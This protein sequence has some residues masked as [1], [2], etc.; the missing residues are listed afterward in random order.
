[1][2]PKRETRYPSP[3]DGGAGVGLARAVEALQGVEVIG[4]ELPALDHLLRHIA[5]D[6]LE[7]GDGAEQLVRVDDLISGP[8]GAAEQEDG[9]EV[10][11]VDVDRPAGDGQP[12]AP[13]FEDEAPDQRLLQPRQ[14]REQRLEQRYLALAQGFYQQLGGDGAAGV[15]LVGELVQPVLRQVGAVQQRRAVDLHLLGRLD[16]RRQHFLGDPRALIVEQGLDHGHLAAFDQRLRDGLGNHA[17]ARDRG[18]VLDGAAAN[19]IDQLGVVEQAAADQNRMRDLAVVVGQHCD[20]VV[21]RVGFVGE[22]VGQ[23][24][25]HR[26]FDLLD[27]PAQDLRHQLAFAVA[28]PGVVAIQPAEDL[29]QGI[30]RGDILAAG[31]IEQVF[32]GIFTVLED[33]RVRWDRVRSRD[34]RHDA[35]RWVAVVKLVLTRRGTARALS[36][37]SPPGRGRGRV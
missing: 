20:Q 21:G 3:F 35:E 15:E 22:P 31:E 9:G 17:A 32:E 26:A 24:A 18:A 11:L 13:R 12:L 29:G 23:A 10:A 30:A 14:A 34:R 6:A 16:Q 2:R 5:G 37:P 33:D 4:V 8:G 1:M 27:Q 28:D 36:R 25:P 19:D 7:E